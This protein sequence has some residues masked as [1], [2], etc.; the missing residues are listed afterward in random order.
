MLRYQKERDSSKTLSLLDFIVYTVSLAAFAFIV[1]FA[2][3]GSPHARHRPPL[4][5]DIKLMSQNQSSEIISLYKQQNSVS[6]KL[7]V[8]NDNIV[9][10]Y[11]NKSSKVIHVNIRNNQVIVPVTL[12]NNGKIIDCKLL[13]DTGAGFITVSP[14]IASRLNIHDEQKSSMV[15]TVADG[16]QVASITTVINGARIG[17]SVAQNLD[18]S[19]MGGNNPDFDGLLG[20]NFIRNFKY[21]VDFDKQVLIWD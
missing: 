18:I 9:P 8:R 11:M 15:S 19:V 13:L 17:R 16:R 3:C 6:P 20:M 14:E 5:P 2:F 10:D 12:F 4:E 21:H 7:L 1:Y